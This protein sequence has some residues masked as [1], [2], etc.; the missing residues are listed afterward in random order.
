MDGIPSS[1]DARGIHG[2][3]A[4]QPGMTRIDGAAFSGPELRG[5]Q[6]PDGA[7]RAMDV[8]ISAALIVA[9]LPVMAVIALLIRVTSGPGVII[10]HMRIGQDGVSFPCLKFRSMVHDADRVLA[11]HLTR[12]PSARA[13]WEQRGKLAR[14]PRITIIGSIIRRTSLDELPQ[15]FNVLRGE[16]SMVGPR[17]V[18]MA[19][20][21]THYVG[22]A[23][24]LY[25]SVRPGLT[26]L[27]QIS[28]RS[29]IGYA[30]RVRLD[31]EY[32]RTAS[33]AMDMRILLLTPWAV[34]T[35]RGAH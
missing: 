28:G 4:Q 15:L 5:R 12:D 18:V 24:A 33:F 6:R 32:V 26:G 21:R 34:L 16:M 2:H 23:A 31:C 14:D 7:K 17:P 25:C 29:R 27:W 22:E 9:F 8:L 19:E 35:A 3:L 20:L 1:A 10:R 11:L 30:D 13:E